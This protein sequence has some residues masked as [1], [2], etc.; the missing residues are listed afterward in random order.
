MGEAETLARKAMTGNRGHKK[1][2]QGRAATIGKEIYRKFD[3]GPTKWRS[4]HVLWFFRD[5]LQNQRQVAPA[6]MYDYWRACRAILEGLDRYGELEP[7]LR[8]PWMTRTGEMPSGSNRGRKM[9]LK[10]RT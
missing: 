1:L 5:F 4:K 9:K 6:T 7:T 8:G 3:I 10:R 2:Y